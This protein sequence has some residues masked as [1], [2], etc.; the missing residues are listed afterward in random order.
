MALDFPK[1]AEAVHYICDASQKRG[2]H[3]DAVKLNKVLWYSD[4]YSYL[5]TG[6]SMTGATYIR[7]SKGPVPKHILAA[8]QEL[9]RS[10]KIRRGK[11]PETGMWH[12]EYASLADPEARVFLPA[13]Q[14]IVDDV[15]NYVVFGTTSKAISDQTHG[16]IWE[17]AAEGEEIPLFT[18]FAEELGDLTEEHVRAA[19]YGL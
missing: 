19:S 8:I 10:G 12:V 15:L 5:S 7:K 17:I 9:E 13:E 3:I 2:R 6:N 14:E 11:E 1:F 16:E 4:A 18:V